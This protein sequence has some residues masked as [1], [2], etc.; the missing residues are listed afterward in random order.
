ML[1]PPMYFEGNEI[2]LIFLPGSYHS[3]IE[4][5]VNISSIKNLLVQGSG[6]KVTFNLIE[7]FY[8]SIDNV[9]ISGLTISEVDL[10]SVPRKESSF[11][12]FFYILGHNFLLQRF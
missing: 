6:G 12:F 4:E 7:M 2:Q 5:G 3:S 9:T 10:Y 8:F 1:P 11:E